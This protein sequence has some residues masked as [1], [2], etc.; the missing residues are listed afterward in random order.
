MQ[1]PCMICW[2]GK[3]PGHL[4]AHATEAVQC[5]S[6]GHTRKTPPFTADAL[7]RRTLED[8]DNT[9]ETQWRCLSCKG[10]HSWPISRRKLDMIKSAPPRDEQLQ[11]VLTPIKGG[12]HHAPCKRT[13]HAD[14]LV[15]RMWWGP[16][17]A[18]LSPCNSTVN[19]TGNVREHAWCQSIK[20]LSK[21]RHE[22]E[23]NVWLPK[24]SANM[25]CIVGTCHF[26][27]EIKC[28]ERAH[29]GISTYT[30]ACEYQARHWITVSDHYSFYME[31]LH[32][33]STRTDQIVKSV[34]ST[35]LTF[36]ISEK[37]INDD[38]QQYTG[39]TWRDFCR[40]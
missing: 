24:I 23:E 7:S 20:S 37:I 38:H 35:F 31:G 16:Y 29:G 30:D 13:L 4:A 25:G 21:C 3:R 1:A 26:C 18:S 40:Q 9:T 33:I 6:R 15:V 11:S 12:W 17:H 14:R 27:Q 28:T 2:E 19:D 36:G 22:A 39:E 5:Q 8:R 10:R 32:L 34:K